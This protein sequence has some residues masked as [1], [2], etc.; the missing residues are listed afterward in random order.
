MTEGT[1]CPVEAG[2]DENESERAPSP[3]A[4]A[5]GSWPIRRW[6]GSRQADLPTPGR[7]GTER[8]DTVE[9]VRFGQ[10]GAMVPNS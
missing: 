1:I 10:S 8:A 4:G 9:R 2:A 3:A 6:V 7:P 5:A